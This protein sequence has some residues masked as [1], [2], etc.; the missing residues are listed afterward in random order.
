M[1]PQ[2][3]RELRRINP[4]QPAVKLAPQPVDGSADA[5]SAGKYIIDVAK[6]TGMT[7]AMLTLR[8]M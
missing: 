1:G 4:V 8:G 7:P 3:N 6:M 5:M 2:S